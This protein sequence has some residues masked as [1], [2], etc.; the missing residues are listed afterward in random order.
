[1]APFDRL[2]VRSPQPFDILPAQILIVGSGASVEGVLGTVEVTNADGSVLTSDVI[3]TS[4]GFGYSV[5]EANLFVAQPA[6]QVGTLTVTADNPSGDPA[7]EHRVVV[8]ITFGDRVVDGSYVGY[9]EY[10]VVG[11]DT[12]FGI[13]EREYGDGNAWPRLHAANRDIVPNPDALTIGTRL[14]IP[15]GV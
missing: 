14:R 5:F 11:G 7:R 15:F 1:M 4:A 10:T 2:T 8:P 9:S 3:R 12:L 6:S 13:A